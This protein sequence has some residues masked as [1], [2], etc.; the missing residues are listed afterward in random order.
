MV[1]IGG[2]QLCRGYLHLEAGSD[3]FIDDPFVPGERLYRT[4]DLAWR[5]PG[6]GIRLAGR[7]DHQIKIRGFRVEPAEVEAALLSH[8]HVA[9]ATVFARPGEGGA[10]ELVALS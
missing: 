9:Q 7:A 3:V 5:L 10:P 1:F 8:P 2:A 4:G 6:G